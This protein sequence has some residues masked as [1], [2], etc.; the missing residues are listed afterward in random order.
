MPGRPTIDVDAPQN[1][2]RVVNLSA[3]LPW[4]LYAS[5][6]RFAKDQDL[7]MSQVVRRAIREYLLRHTKVLKVKGETQ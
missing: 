3:D 2:R 6:Q 5:L 7:Q 4:E 1:G